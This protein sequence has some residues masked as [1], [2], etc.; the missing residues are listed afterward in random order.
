MNESRFTGNIIGFIGMKIGVFL[1]VL[2]TLGLGVPWAVAFKQKWFTRHQ[3]VDGKK[4]V[5]TGSGSGLFGNY[6]KW[7]LLTIITFGIYGLWIPLKIQTWVTKHTHL[8]GNMILETRKSL[9]SDKSLIGTQESLNSD[10]PMIESDGSITSD[11]IQDQ[12]SRSRKLLLISIGLIGVEVVLFFLGFLFG[13]NEMSMERSGIL[14][15]L[16][17]L[18]YML[19]HIGIPLP[20]MFGKNKPTLMAVFMVIVIIYTLQTVAGSIIALFSGAVIAP[21]TLLVL[22]VHLAYTITFTMSAL[23]SVKYSKEQ[24]RSIPDSEQDKNIASNEEI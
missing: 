4:L 3:I 21:V 18:G 5:F 15:I 7:F 2:F 14:I 17:Q 1:I 22:P 12:L 6:I 8:E 23:A 11:T 24:D 13:G 10:K 9:N 16:I 19:F 20:Q